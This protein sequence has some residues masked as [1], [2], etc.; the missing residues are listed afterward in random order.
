[1]LDKFDYIWLVEDDMQLPRGIL[2]ELIESDA[3]VAIADYP[4]HK[5][6]PTVK[7]DMY[8]EFLSAGLGCVLIKPHV[9]EKLERPWFRTDTQYIGAE[10]SPQ[11]VRS[12]PEEVHGLQDTDFWVRVR[13]IPNITIKVIETKIGQ[14]NLVEPKLP[15]HGNHTGEQ[16]VVETWTL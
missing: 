13:Q 11:P 2:Q 5:N 12:K 4:V 8:G 7:R 6:L 3:D 14:Y 16:Y 9:F 15:K 10:L 1:M